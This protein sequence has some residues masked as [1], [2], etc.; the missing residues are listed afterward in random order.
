MLLGYDM[1]GGETTI[2]GEAAS[3]AIRL[4]TGGPRRRR[5]FTLI[6]LLVVIAII[7]ILAAILFPVYAKVKERARRVV[8]TSNL[9]QIGFAIKLYQDDYE[10]Y[11]LYLVNP[12]NSTFGYPGGNTKYLEPY[13]GG[14]T[15]IF[16]CQDDYMNGHINFDQGWEY[17]DG[18]SYAYHMGAWFQL[19]DPGWLADQISRWQGRYIVAACPWHRHIQGW[20]PRI[21]DI[22]LRLDGAVRNFKWP[23][24][25]WS[26]EPYQTGY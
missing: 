5:A 16:I 21:R 6:E 14:N 17:F 9:R 7:A 18:T 19:T 26:D 4:N 8:C 12:G 3:M 10:Q 22:S 1:V 15:A 2:A 20:D 13:C 25:N 24:N 23:S 11:P